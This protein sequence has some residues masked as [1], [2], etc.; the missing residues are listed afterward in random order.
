MRRMMKNS[1]TEA[2]LLVDASNTFNS[3]NHKAALRNVHILCPALAPVLINTYREDS[4]LFIDGDVILSREG[5]MPGDPLAMPIYAIGTLPLIQQ[6]PNQC[7]SAWFA[8]D[9]TAG[10]RLDNIKT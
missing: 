4:P 2:V 8:D 1:N 10:G 9:A 5:T 7:K 6:L 3:L